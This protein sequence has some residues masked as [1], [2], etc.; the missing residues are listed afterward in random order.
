MGSAVRPDDFETRREHLRRLSDEELHARFWALT[1]QIVS[2]LI[3]TVTQ[4][5][6]FGTNNRGADK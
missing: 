6:V 5:R 3:A 2:P 1:E 4:P